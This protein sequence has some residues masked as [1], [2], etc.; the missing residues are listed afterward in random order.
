PAIVTTAGDSVAQ[1]PIAGWHITAQGLRS[2]GFL[3]LRAQS[4]ATLSAVLVMTTPWPRVLRALRVFRVPAVFVVILGFTYRYI[5]L[6]LETASDMAE[7]R[8]A[9]TIGVL[10]PADRRRIATASI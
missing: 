7:A 5:F 6:L 8:S 9:R 1:L 4:A 3:V 2:A 10:E